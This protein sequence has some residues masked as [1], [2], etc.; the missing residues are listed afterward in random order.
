MHPRMR[1][2]SVLFLVCVVLFGSVG[3]SGDSESELRQAPDGPL[4]LGPYPAGA[5]VQLGGVTIM[6]SDF[7]VLE[8]TATAGSFIY[9]FSVGP[10]EYAPEGTRFVDLSV[11]VQDP[12]HRYFDDRGLFPSPAVLADGQRI[13]VG[14]RARSGGDSPLIIEQME[15]AIPETARDV[16]LQLPLSGESTAV[17][18]FRLW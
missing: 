15:F 1:A 4:I 7:R 13:E 2:L 18:S 6:L 9:R 8:A 17:P 12:S 16:V 10:T 5:E 3:C 11:E 14:E